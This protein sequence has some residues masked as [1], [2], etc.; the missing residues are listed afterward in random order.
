MKPRIWLPMLLCLILSGVVFAQGV[1]TASLNGTVYSF[2]DNKTEPLPGA[3]VIAT[4][5]PTGTVFKAIT[6]Q[7]GRFLMPAV[8]V[9][10]PYTIVVSV[11]G[12][13][14]EKMD[15]VTLK[16]GEDKNLVF[17]LTLLTI[18]ESVKVTATNP[19]INNSRTGAAQNVSTETIETLPSI[20]RQLSDFTRLA[21]QFASGEDQGSFN[22]GGRSSRYNNI[23]I[24]GAQNNDLF[25]LGNT[26]TPGG[27][28]ET[29][30]ITLD[31]IQEF[32]IVL[33]PYDVRQGMFTGGGVNV[34]TRSGTNRFQ[35]S[36]FFTGRNE[37]FVG[38]GP[39]K[40]PFAKFSEGVF[41]GRIGGPIIKNKLFFFVSGER[42][43][44]NEPEDFRIDDTGSSVDW[45]GAK[46][47]V[48]DAQRFI[49]ILNSKYGY[50]A[51][52]YHE[53][54]NNID[55]DNLFARIDW[56]INAKN[57]LTL[58]HNYVKANRDILRRNSTSN[59]QFG[60]NGYFFGSTT[61]STVLQ[62]NS[63]LSKS[64]FNEL[65]LNYT[66]IRDTR[67]GM[68]NAFP[69]VSVRVGDV[70]FNAGTEQYSTANS[71]N[72]D[73]IELTDNFTWFAGDHVFTIGTHNEF[74]KFNNVYL[75]GS[76][77]VYSFNNLDDLE[78]GKASRYSIT[79]SKTGDPLAPAKFWVYQLGFYVGDQWAILPNLKLTL[80]IRTDVPIFPDKPLT[81]PLAERAFGVPTDQVPSGNFLWSPRVGFNWDINSDRKHQ[82]RGG[83]GIFAGRTP[84]VWL[85]NQYSNTGMDIIR[86]TYQTNVP[87][88]NPDPNTQT[89][90]TSV[91]A[92]ATDINLI[93]KD[94]RFPEVLKTNI[95]Y[96]RELPF[97]FTGTVEFVYQKNIKEIAYQ[98]L[99]IAPTGKTQPDG[100]SIY[101]TVDPKNA[102]R[103][104]VGYVNRDFQNAIFLTNTNKGYQYSLSA[105][106]QK[107]WAA[108]DMVNV[109]YTY[110]KSKDIL[111]G[112]SSRAI[113]NW[114]YNI[115]TNDP[116]N[117][118]LVYSNFDR[119]HRIVF[120]A[121]KK[122]NIL[123]GCPTLISI[124][125]NGNS[126][127]PYSSR[128]TNDYNGDGRS[129]DSI[130]VPRDSS[131]II[132][133]DGK[134]AEL[135]AFI[136]GD[137]ALKANRG[138]ILP[139]NASREPWFH[140]IDLK[141]AQQLRLPSLKAHKLEI[142]IDI[143]NLLNLF[144]ADWGV[145]KYIDF[146]DTPLTY[147]GL[148]KEGKPTFTF[149]GRNPDKRY[150]INQA[151]SRWRA[152]LGVRYSFN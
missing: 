54:T 103:W 125:Y 141:L 145:Y 3:L 58:R 62:W 85:S 12:F 87:V 129:N 23:Q 6:R 10:G 96:D 42:K 71:L 11:D 134:Y 49:S 14:E 107:T 143:L 38:D 78:K 126:G 68:G 22:A 2:V 4:H 77:G 151:L 66:T 105:Q 100:R 63:T 94:F 116:N 138:K 26:G 17:K 52:T 137:P 92:V 31:A 8:R 114:G 123:K 152:Q 88:F 133:N 57:R 36:V 150:L 113:S 93:D 132:L 108:G 46:V 39:D 89:R 136:E 13:K 65:V 83:I 149:N 91:G 148:N 47:S 59:F 41:G 55:S 95:A 37:K 106:L 9:G 60:N 81:N 144:D 122:L 80:G 140:G 7:D 99:N 121:T 18:Q 76:F 21:P 33:A 73:L 35:G 1:T 24:D 15:N 120:A 110:G 117:P 28:A 131:D 127:S 48:A 98:N 104:I 29:T 25:G 69:A 67:E 97:G 44:K 75:D 118:E 112:T 74:F 142:S 32:Q 135:D 119:R 101:G 82:L 16:L 109:S 61:N 115:I 147:K 40:L 139:R 146:D 90:P 111:S 19:I 84:Y 128:Y 79:Y 102:D 86:Y 30:P 50:D 72:Q 27:Q 56:N 43:R 51:G 5:L 70:Y 130:Y 20:A 53:I 124:F 64:S 45:G 34:I